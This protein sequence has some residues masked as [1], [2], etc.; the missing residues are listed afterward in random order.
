MFIMGR[1]VS[2]TACHSLICQ[3][4]MSHLTLYVIIADCN[5]AQAQYRTLTRRLM[6]VLMSHSATP[7]QSPPILRERHRDQQKVE[8]LY[9]DSVI[10]K[11]LVLEAWQVLTPQ[12]QLHKYHQMMQMSRLT[13]GPDVCLAVI[14]C[15]FQ[16]FTQDD[17]WCHPENMKKCNDTGKPNQANL[18]NDGS[19]RGGDC[20]KQS[21]L[22]SRTCFAICCICKATLLCVR[23]PK[24]TLL[25]YP[26]CVTRYLYIQRALIW[27]QLLWL[28]INIYCYYY[29]CHYYYCH[30]NY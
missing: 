21:E 12:V 11:T 25:F 4:K 24:L 17:L 19:L 20:L 5:T 9:T 28:L 23:M 15:I 27:L 8:P 10:L 26:I 13:E 30:Y 16:C 18:Q 6:K 29:Y 14:R 1:M 7:P 22:Q 3:T 2:A